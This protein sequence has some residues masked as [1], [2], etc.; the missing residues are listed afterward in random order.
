MEDIFQTAKQIQDKAWSVIEETG[1]VTHWSSVGATI[2]LVG[3][4]KTGLLINNRDID[5]HI[6]TNPF[7]LSDSFLAISRLAE[8]KRIKTVSYSNLLES[9]DRCIEWHAFY[10]DQDGNSWQIDMIHIVTGSPYAG[11]FENV[12]ERISNVLTQETREAILRIK[13]AIPLDKKAMSIQIYKAVIADGVR[14]AEAFWQWQEQHPDEGIIT[15]V[16]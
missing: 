3:S 4:L 14:D 12:A 16:P 2:N 5:F 6:Y 7:K 13:N 10:D 11:Y 9:E 1:V 8:N 15:W